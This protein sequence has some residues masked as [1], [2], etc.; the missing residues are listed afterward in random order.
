MLQGLGVHADGA[1]FAVAAGPRRSDSRRDL[2]GLLFFDGEAS[3]P[4]LFCPTA[5]PVFFRFALA[6]DRRAAVVEHP[7]RVD[8]REI[9]GEYRVTVLR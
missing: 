1:S 8:D 7:V 2:F 4:E 5:A 9:L 6:P 3:E